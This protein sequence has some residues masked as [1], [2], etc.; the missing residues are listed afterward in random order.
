MTQLS[1]SQMKRIAIQK[2]TDRPPKN[3]RVPIFPPDAQALAQKLREIID[4]GGEQSPLAYA[5]LSRLCVMWVPGALHDAGL[6]AGQYGQVVNELID[7]M[8]EL[9]PNGE[10]LPERSAL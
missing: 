4:A 10:G 2:G 7:L 8:F 6:G 1:K 3:P 5:A 9:F